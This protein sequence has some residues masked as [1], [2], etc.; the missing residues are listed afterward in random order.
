L[1]ARLS[2]WPSSL[3]EALS[4]V[5]SDWCH[6]TVDPA[7]REDPKAKRLTVFAELA[8]YDQELGLCDDST[9][10]AAVSQIIPDN[11]YPEI[12]VGPEVGEEAVDSDSDHNS[13]DSV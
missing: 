2:C 8:A 6:N 1:Q 7:L 3:G 12:S 9:P 4:R 11:R 10:A 13:G 5:D